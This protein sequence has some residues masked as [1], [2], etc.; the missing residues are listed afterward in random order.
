MTEPKTVDATDVP[1]ESQVIPDGQLSDADLAKVSG[2]VGGSLNKM[3]VEPVDFKPKGLLMGMEVE[4]VD[5]KPRP[6]F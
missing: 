6:G 5:F 1:A 3:E 4:P 2:G